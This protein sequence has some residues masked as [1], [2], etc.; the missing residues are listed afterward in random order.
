VKEVEDCLAAHGKRPIALLGDW[1]GLSERWCLIHATHADA[2]EVRLMAETGA[3]VGLCPVTE[4]NLGDGLFAGVEFKALG[5]RFGV[6]TDSNV[7]ISASGEL[8]TLDYAQRLRDTPPHRAGGPRPLDGP[9]GA[10]ACLSGGVQ[11]LGLGTAG[12]AVGAPAD[13]VVLDAGH[14][15]FAGRGGDA[16]LDSWIFGPSGGPSARS[17]CRDGG[18]WTAAGTW[19]GV[20]WKRERGKCWSG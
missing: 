18:W 9:H 17:G 14:M 20:P 4:A 3:V 16:V 13:V 12:L 8:C 7:A 1:A 10:E 11:A 19:R 2:A 15:A 5:G 6:G